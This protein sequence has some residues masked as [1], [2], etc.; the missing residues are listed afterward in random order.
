MRT[1]TT[2]LSDELARTLD[3]L[4]EA[5]GRSKSWLVRTALSDYIAH[6]RDLDRLTREGLDAA[7]SGDLVTHE[8]VLS[9]L[10]EWGR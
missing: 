10:D 5:E 1:V 2:Q 9:D 4:S 8:D 7:R 3:K 6:K